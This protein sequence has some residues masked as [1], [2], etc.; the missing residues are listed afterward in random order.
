MRTLNNFPIAKLTWCP[1][2]LAA[3]CLFADG[4]AAEQAADA[5]AADFSRPN[6]LFAIADDWSYGHASAYGCKWVETPN[7]DRI[8]REGI[9][10]NNA[11][12]PNA[13]CAPS[14]ATILTGRYSW[15]LEE[16]GNHMTFFP[17]KF[18][19]FME[20]LAVDGYQAGYT[21]KGWGPGFANDAAGKPRAITGKKYSKRTAK[22][23]TKA[24]SRLDYAANFGDFLADVPDG[25]PWVFWYGTTEPHRGYEFKSGVRAGKKLSDIDRVPG[26][27]PDN[28]T[29][30]HDMLDYAVE[31]EHYDTH[32]GRIVKQL[33]AKGQLDNTLIVCTSDHGMPFPRVKGQAYLHSNRIPLAIRWPA[34]IQGSERVV[35]D[36]INFTDLAPTF[37]EVA[38]VRDPGPGMQPTSGR[39]LTDIFAKPDSGQVIPDRDHVVVG[40]ERHDIGRPNNWGYPIRGLN[41]GQFL[42]VHNFKVDRWPAGHPTTGYLN[43]D[44]SPTK[45]DILNL[46]RSGEA[47]NW[48]QLCF[49]RRPEFELYNLATDGDCVHNLAEEE[50]YQGVLQEMKQRLQSDL[51]QQGDPRMD[52]R[53]DVFDNYPYSGASTDNFY[54]RYLAKDPNLKAGWVNKTDFE[55]EPIE[56]E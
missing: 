31:V 16:A 21:G 53:G 12:T 3:I 35:E 24:I 11:Y 48:W 38:G 56:D 4:Q 47:A 26:Y 30:R 13:K 19:G 29:T 51:K 2:F 50:R 6:I 34:G 27:W 41:D 25:T 17:V 18:G 40:K 39:S 43:T 14:R 32:L 54:D 46:R 10:F 1:F 22:P 52:G 45:T 7:F 15:Q 37:L 23:P 55:P 36:F 49:G 8:A 9:L 33:E 44:G 28:E 20:R 5:R 42:L